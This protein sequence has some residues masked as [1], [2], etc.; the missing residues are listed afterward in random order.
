MSEK[1]TPVQTVVVDYVCDSC[2][3][4]HMLPT[5][6]TLT[7]NPP[8]YPHKCDKCGTQDVFLTRY[9][10]GRHIAQG[11]WKPAEPGGTFTL[12]VKGHK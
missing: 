11:D 4:G 3:E 12:R 9:P 6:I 1:Q 10:Q 2:G 5:G 8:Q 7:S